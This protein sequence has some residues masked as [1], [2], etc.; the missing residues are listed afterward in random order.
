[1]SPIKA[2][3]RNKWVRLIL[4]LD[5]IAIIFIIALVINN[6]T[7]TAVINFMVTPV[8]ATITING[9]DGYRNGGEAYS[10][11]PG[12]Y[13]VQISHPDLD[14]KTFV[15]NLE[16]NHNVTVSTFLSQN[17]SFEFYELRDNLSSFEMLAQ[18]A[19]AGNNQTIDQD[20]SAEA[21]I[22][23]FQKN[24]NLYLTELPIV[25][26]TPSKYGM[27]YGVNYEYDTL[28]IQD[29]DSLSECNKTICFYITDT[30]GEKEQF[31]LSVIEKFGFDKNLY[32]TVYEKVDYE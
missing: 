3:F 10:F 19:S 2:F 28:T 12:T 6:A 23:N 25:D 18:V 9:R 4:I 24:Y 27:E 29:G 1:M 21:F 20:T 13:E 7:K 8:D 26:Q 5:L 22:T 30:S 15:L 16:A 17:G 11:A 32:Q 14:S 31:A